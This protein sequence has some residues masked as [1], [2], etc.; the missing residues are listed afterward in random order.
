[1]KKMRLV[2]AM[3][4]AMMFLMGSVVACD[5]KNSVVGTWYYSDSDIYYSE[6]FIVINSITLTKDGKYH[7]DGWGGGTYKV[8]GNVITLT[9]T[10]D[11]TTKINIEKKEGK[12]T[13]SSGTRI[14][15]RTEAELR[16]ARNQTKVP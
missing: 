11:G 6:L 1:M 5:D 3:T 9:S 15:Y 16:A 8:D 2:V 14:Y 13:L 12:T 7:G 4:L 10:L